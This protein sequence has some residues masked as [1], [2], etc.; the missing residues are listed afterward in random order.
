MTVQQLKEALSL[1]LLAGEEGLSQE[2]S[3]CY[4]G[5]LLSWVMGRAKA[6][7]A[8]LTV[9]GNIS[10]LAVAHEAAHQWWYGL[11]GSNQIENAWLDEDAKRK[12]DQQGICVLGAEENSYRLALQI[13]RLLS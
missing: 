3:G 11:V 6:G 1:K 4:I 10:A 12:A 8:W 13:G 2:V 7:D 9:M 5:D